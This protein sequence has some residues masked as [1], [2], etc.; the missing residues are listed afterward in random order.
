MQR[1]APVA[2]TVEVLDD[3]GHA[4]LDRRGRSDVRHHRH[5]RELLA[6][7]ELIHNELLV[8]MRSIFDGRV[9]GLPAV[10]GK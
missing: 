5:A 7:N 8:E 10:T 1:R 9:E 2:Y 4:A 3:H 6:S